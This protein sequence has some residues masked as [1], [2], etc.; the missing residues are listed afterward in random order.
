MNDIE[1]RNVRYLEKEKDFPSFDLEGIKV[2]AVIDLALCGKNWFRIFDWKTGTPG[3]ADKTQLAVYGLFAAR[4]WGWDPEKVKFTFVYLSP[5]T[6]KQEESITSGDIKETQKLIKESYAEML[7]LYNGGSPAA[8]DFPQ[9][10][11][12]R[13]GRCRYRELCGKQF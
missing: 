1:E 9:S 12:A 3:S 2:Y 10:P 7:A 13:C 4:E 8:E 6:V 5:E 11:G